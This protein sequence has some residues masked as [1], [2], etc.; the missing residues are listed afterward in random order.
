MWESLSDY[1]WLCLSAFLAGGINALAGGGTLL[2]FPTLTGVLSQTFDRA[3]A[4][5]LANGTSTVALVPASLGSAWGFRRELTAL[6][7][8]LMW[9]LPPSLLGGAIGSLLVT[10]LPPA[11]F[12][13]L[14]PWLILTATLLFLLQPML[15][16]KKAMVIV[17]NGM[18]VQQRG[19][20]Q[21]T[22]GA[23]AGMIV[24]QLLIAIYGGYFGAGIGIL[25]LSGLSLMGLT[26]IHEMNGLKTVL[27]TAINS[28][29]VIVFIIE[30]KVVWPYA[31]I[32][33]ATSIVAGFLAAHYSRQIRGQ[34]VRYFVITIGFA[35]AGWFF[36]K[37]YVL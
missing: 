3:V 24:L 17:E 2:T 13:L 30:R 22:P 29:A 23:I 12:A 5:V 32:M 1:F 19:I 31:L 37:T 4:N 8:L 15:V 16:R 14:V 7:W 25:M 34:Y 9:L 20:E 28:V 6:R 10:K 18:E 11:I 26:N 36:A 27:A 35:L 33:M 21:C